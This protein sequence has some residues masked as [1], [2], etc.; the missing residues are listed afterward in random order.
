MSDLRVYVKDKNG[1]E[2]SFIERKL[3]ELNW[4]DVLRELNLAMSVFEENRMSDC[5][6]NLRMA[7]ITLLAKM[8]E[9]LEKR[10]PPIQPDKTPNPRLLLK[11][12]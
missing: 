9:L 4:S 5:C 3:Q 6:N 7:L 11:S 10:P 8:Y 12:M 2:R 1:E